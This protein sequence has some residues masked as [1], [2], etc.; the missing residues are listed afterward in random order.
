MYL[1]ETNYGRRML[2]NGNMN[3]FSTSESRE[4][5]QRIDIKSRRQNNIDQIKQKNHTTRVD[6]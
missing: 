5:T 4:H 1:E 6:V 3:P 2:T